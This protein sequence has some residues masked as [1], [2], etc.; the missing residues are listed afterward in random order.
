M[1]IRDLEYLAALAEYKHFRRDADDCH[2]SQW[3]A[4]PYLRRSFCT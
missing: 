1:N 4:V 2:V 3:E